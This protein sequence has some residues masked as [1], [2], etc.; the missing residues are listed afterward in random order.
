[1]QEITQSRLKELFDY[2]AETGEFIRRVST[3]P[4]AQTGS[5]AGCISSTTGYRR[6]KIDGHTFQAHRLV[7]LYAHG[8]FPTEQIDHISGVKTDNRL[9]NLRECSQAENNQ[10]QAPRTGGTSIY[11][12]VCW[13]RQAQKWKAR[14]W[15]QGKQKYLGL[16]A[17]ELEAYNAYL[18]AKATYHQFQPTQRAAA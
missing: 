12:G 10:N 7:W 2:S 14:I 18:A 5:I 1:M 15:I 4:R 17:N 6:I 9:E 11:P 13:A 3:S 8:N 16:F